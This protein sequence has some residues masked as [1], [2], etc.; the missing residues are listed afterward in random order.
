M[1]GLL[2]FPAATIE[3]STVVFGYSLLL[4]KIVIAGSKS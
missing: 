3:L 2:G 4:N 1:V